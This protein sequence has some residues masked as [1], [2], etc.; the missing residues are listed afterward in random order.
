VADHARVQI[1]V[2]AAGGLLAAA[3]AAIRS[4]QPPGTH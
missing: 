3:V 2:W 4:R 1:I